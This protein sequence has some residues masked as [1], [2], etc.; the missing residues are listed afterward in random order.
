MDQTVRD[1]GITCFIINYCMPKQ[2]SFGY[3]AHGGLALRR[4]IAILCPH[5]L[6]IVTQS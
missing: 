6:T 2:S 4:N 1:I 5:S 3:I